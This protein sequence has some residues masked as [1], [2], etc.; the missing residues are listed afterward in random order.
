MRKYIGITIGPILDTMLDAVSPAGMWFSSFLFSDITKR[1]CKE[2]LHDFQSKAVVLYSPY[3]SEEEDTNTDGVGKYHDRVLFSVEAEEQDDI[4]GTLQALIEKVKKETV[5][6]FE[7]LAQYDRENAEAFLVEYLQIHFMIADHIEKNIILDFSDSLS[8]L[9][10]IKSFPAD[11]SQNP[12]LMLLSGTDK[13]KNEAV[14]ES[15]LYQ[16]IQNKEQLEQNGKIRNIQ[17]IAQDDMSRKDSSYRRYE[18]FAVVSADGDNMGK[19]LGELNN[20][21]I[22]D[23]SK[24]LFA[25]AG[26]ASEKIKEFGG[27][28][29]YAGGDDLLFLAPVI[30]NGGETILNLCDHIRMDFVSLMKEQGFEVTPTLSFGIAIQYAKYP[31]Y[32]ALE[33]SRGLLYEAKRG[34]K[35]AAALNL[36][37][38]SGQSIRFTVPNESLKVV[39][40]FLQTEDLE[41]AKE[42][43]MWAILYTLGHY[44]A[45]FLELVRNAKEKPDGV[46]SRESFVNRWCNMFDN[47]GQEAYRNYIEKTA[48]FFYI[49]YIQKQIG[50]EAGGIKASDE[51]ENALNSLR[52]LL[53]FKKFLQ[54]KGSE[55]NEYISD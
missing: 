52:M 23:F 44:Q 19:T 49:H 14:K 33:L 11:N 18:Y 17:S 4:R 10:L 3:Y 38:H 16:S 43:T 7:R 42:Q 32:E 28:T 41:E 6:Y 46:M 45:L 55:E 35:N 9:E 8:A 12:I 30:G 22:T 34:E 15:L 31:L 13:G 1:L 47:A 27:M 20:E 53:R 40:T 29:I 36:Q 25:H 26:K 5:R 21:Q 54:E 48:D 39:D 50:I 2:I 37:K 51:A 24:C